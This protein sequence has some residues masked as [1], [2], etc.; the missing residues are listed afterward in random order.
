MRMSDSFLVEVDY[1]PAHLWGLLRT[2]RAFRSVVPALGTRVGPGR[3]AR[4]APIRGTLVCEVASSEPAG[5]V[6]PERVVLVSVCDVAGGTQ[7]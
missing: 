7:K 2:D 5:V 4:A 6:G 1:V 3:A